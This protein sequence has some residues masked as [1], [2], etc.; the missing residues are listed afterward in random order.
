MHCDLCNLL[1]KERDSVMTVNKYYRFLN[2]LGIH[3]LSYK[4]GPS[5]CVNRN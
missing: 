5:S 1:P 4:K 3:D 2:V